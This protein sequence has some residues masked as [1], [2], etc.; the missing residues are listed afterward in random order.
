MSARLVWKGILFS[1][2][3]F[4]L[5]VTMGF[6]SGGGTYYPEKETFSRFSGQ[7]KITAPG[8]R[9]SGFTSVAPDPEPIVAEKSIFQTFRDTTDRWM[10]GGEIIAAP[11]KKR[12]EL[13]QL[14]TRR[15]TQGVLGGMS[16][17]KTY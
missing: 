11:Q 5:L 10:G 3:I 15:P 8:A 17:M 7:A 1:V 2:S 13:Q 16:V 14:Q 6:G 12:S 9:T 4:M